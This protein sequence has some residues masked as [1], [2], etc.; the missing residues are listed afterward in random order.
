[1]R[2]L[3]DYFR[4]KDVLFTKVDK[5]D[6]KELGSR[7]KID[8]YEA[9]DTKRYV[10]AIFV[11]RQNSR[12]ITKN[13]NELQKLFEEL[14]R[15]RQRDYKYKLCMISSPLCSKARTNLLHLKWKVEH[16]SL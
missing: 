15:F 4:L 12:F 5:I 3:C 11:I 9:V 7:K 8:I 2:E 6:I 14:K 10:W 1:M 16:G 13:S